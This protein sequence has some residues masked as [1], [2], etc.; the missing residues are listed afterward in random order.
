MIEIKY[1]FR[2]DRDQ[3][4]RHA[5]NRST[6]SVARRGQLKAV[7][8]RTARKAGPM[9]PVRRIVFPVDYSDRCQAVVP[10]VREAVGRFSAQLTV[11]HA[12]DAGLLPNPEL[13]V[14]DPTWPEE[15]RQRAEKRLR[16]YAA[17]TFPDQ[18]VDCLAQDGE[19]GDVIHKVVQHQG[20]DL[21]MI[22]THGRG[23]VRRLLL[24]SVTAKVLHDIS[25]AVWTDNGHRKLTSPQDVAYKSILCAVD[26][27]EE[28]EAVVR[29]AASLADSY[30]AR[31]SLVHVVEIPPPAME[32]D[33]T[34]YRQQLIDAANDRFRELKSKL[35]MDAPHSAIDGMTAG[36]VCDEAVRRRADL[37]VV[38]RGRD[39]GTFS[40]M[41]SQLYTI[42]R[43]APCPVISI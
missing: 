14:A 21:V 5:Y 6:Q 34:P 38:G 3:D 32:V 25:A 13:A 30:T 27:S 16:E 17:Q 37:I 33:F 15:V 9:L 22:P 1:T 12:Y 7:I 8:P 11:V 19:P 4:S 40:S 31:L 36:S 23:P 10:Y 2:A 39:Q 18:H 29:A 42:V 41:W 24:G 43:D 28:A 26:F 35:G 20:T